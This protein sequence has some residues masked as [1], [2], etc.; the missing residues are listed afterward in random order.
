VDIHLVVAASLLL[1][2]LLVLARQPLPGL[3]DAA[4]L[5]RAAAEVV[6][7]ALRP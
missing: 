1:A 4:D 3:R 6:R 5:V 7:A 2:L